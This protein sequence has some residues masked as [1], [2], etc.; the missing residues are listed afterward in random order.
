MDKKPYN[1]PSNRQGAISLLKRITFVHQLTN[2]Q[3]E[4]QRSASDTA[5]VCCKWI[6]LVCC[7]LLTVPFYLLMVFLFLPVYYCVWPC[8]GCCACVVEE[9][10]E[11]WGIC[12]LVCCSWPFGPL[13]ASIVVVGALMARNYLNLKGKLEL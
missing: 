7:M 5:N 12:C 10:K 2:V 11:K 3:P 13:V 4:T 8:F 9:G 1:S 6:C